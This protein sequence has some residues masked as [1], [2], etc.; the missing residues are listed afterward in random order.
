MKIILGA[1]LAVSLIAAAAPA[2]A[3]YGAPSG[4]PRDW[5]DRAQRGDWRGPR[6]GWDLDRRIDW[7]QERIDHGRADGSLDFREADRVQD[8]LRRIRD[9]ERRERD[10]N[11]GRLDRRARDQLDARLD[12]LNDQIRWLRHNDERRPW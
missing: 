1:A 7:M 4:D 8:E 6:G 12:R 9:H 2:F 5:P 3:Q 10:D 11:G